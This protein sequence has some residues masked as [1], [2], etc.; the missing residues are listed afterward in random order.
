MTTVLRHQQRAGRFGREIRGDDTT[1]AI[2]ADAGES[3]E[4]AGYV[5]DERAVADAIVDRLHAGRSFVFA[6]AR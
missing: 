5:I 3:S 1:N 2:A 6:P 4:I